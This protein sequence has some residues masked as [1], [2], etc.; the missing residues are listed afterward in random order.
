MQRNEIKMLLLGKRTLAF[1]HILPRPELVVSAPIIPLE[2]D[3]LPSPDIPFESPRPAPSPP[4]MP[5]PGIIP[6]SGDGP[7]S[8]GP[9]R[10]CGLASDDEYPPRGSVSGHLR[11]PDHTLN[12]RIPDPRLVGLSPMARFLVE[13]DIPE[14]R[15]TAS[16][17]S[18]RSN[19]YGATSAGGSIAPDDAGSAVSARN[20]QRNTSTARTRSNEPGTRAPFGV[21]P[22]D[23]YTQ[24][25]IFWLPVPPDPRSSPSVQ[26]QEGRSSPPS[27]P[28]CSSE[29]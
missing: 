16:M 18:I 20:H 24:V 7:A 25:G 14:C 23:H 10:Q 11:A 21:D 12:Q 6:G 27:P 8:S 5:S 9:S 22:V 13:S 15:R 26:I 1:L 2:L 19:Q 29:A 28:E 17:P 4:G 3:R